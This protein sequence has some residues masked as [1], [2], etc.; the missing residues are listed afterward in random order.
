MTVYWVDPYLNATTQGSGTTDTTTRSGTYNAPFHIFDLCTGTSSTPT[1]TY[2]NVTFVDGDEIR[3]KGIAFSTLF[4]SSN[5]ASAISATNGIR[6]NSIS[7]AQLTTF[8]ETSII[9]LDPTQTAALMGSCEDNNVISV[10]QFTS[11]TDTASGSYGEA[12]FGAFSYVMYQ[13]YP[14]G[15]NMIALDSNYFPDLT[16]TDEQHSDNE[17]LFNFNNLSNTVSITIS[18]GWTSSLARGG[19]SLVPMLWTARYKNLYVGYNN[20]SPIIWD[21]PELYFISMEDDTVNSSYKGSYTYFY[22]NRHR[23]NLNQ[24]TGNKLPN[25]AGHFYTHVGQ[26]YSQG[27]VT[28]DAGKHFGHVTY[29]YN[30]VTS[31]NTTITFPLI[32]AEYISGT[33]GLNAASTANASYTVKTVY[34]TWCVNRHQT[35]NSVD[36]YWVYANQGQNH[37]EIKFETF[38]SAKQSTYNSFASLGAVRSGNI[39]LPANITFGTNLSS[40][41][42]ASDT[43]FYSSS[44]LSVFAGT[45]TPATNSGNPF[46]TGTVKL[47]PTGFTDSASFLLANNSYGTITNVHLNTLVCNSQNYKTTDMSHRM[48]YGSS[49]FND[50]LTQLVF[51][52]FHFENN[53]YD[54]KP[55]SVIPPKYSAANQKMLMLYNGAGDYLTFQSSGSNPAN[56]AVYYYFPS[57]VSFP[58]Y[59]Q[60]TDNLRLSSQISSAGTY[61]SGACGVK[62]HVYYRDTSQGVKWNSNSGSSYTDLSSVSSDASSP[63]TVTLNLTNLP[64]SGQQKANAALVV[65]E[66]KYDSSSGTVNSSNLVNLHD[67]TIETY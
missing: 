22:C 38:I 13:K 50:P 44:F 35:T 33:S 31:S 4:P 49:A 45:V 26:N 67:L 9:A 47:T 66:F 59:T 17:Y 43:D 23:T 64:S 41:A 53:D 25:S 1:N 21:C 12:G 58:T 28:I 51:P 27:P 14:S 6:A 2:G 7:S 15:F 46:H 34:G 3:I 32:G 29:Q 42:N 24:S 61:A 30:N 37:D 65:M 16:N 55:I 10:A 40:T 54:G 56:L 19:I 48:N 5:Q 8:Q 11:T 60:G 39:V 63:T 62:F 20:V 52:I 18:S 57:N 36:P